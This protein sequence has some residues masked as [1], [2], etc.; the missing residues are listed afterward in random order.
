MMRWPSAMDRNRDEPFVP[1]SPGPHVLK[2]HRTV[3]T[4]GAL[5][6]LGA[7]FGPIIVNPSETRAAQST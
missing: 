2:R 5:R 3:L 4:Y 1:R 7:Y 6:V